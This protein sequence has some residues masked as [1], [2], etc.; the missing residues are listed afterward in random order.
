MVMMIRW[1]PL[2]D[3]RNKEETLKIAK[4]LSSNIIFMRIYFLILLITNIDLRL[5]L[6]TISQ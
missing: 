3:I 5:C 1:R 2:K 6:N 4:S